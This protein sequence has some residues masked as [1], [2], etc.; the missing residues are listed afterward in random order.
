MH[1]HQ[2]CIVIQGSHSIIVEYNV[3]YNTYG[4]C[5]VLQDGIEHENHFNYNLGA[6][7]K[8]IPDANIISIAESDMFP[9]TFWISNPHNHLL[10]NVAAGSQDSGFW[11][12][13]LDTVR[14]P[15]KKQDSTNSINP[16]TAEHGSFKDCVTHS[17]AG[18]GFRTYPNGYSPP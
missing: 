12:E 6:E 16:S 10:G 11:Y 8:V 14:G 15:S 18:D 17:N 5:F 3:A 1:S 9:A 4:H 13:F 2:R 7:Q